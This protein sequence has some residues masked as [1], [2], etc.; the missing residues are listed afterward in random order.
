MSQE[1]SVGKARRLAAILHADVVGFSALMSADEA[2]T[3]SAVS[4]ALKLAR[5]TVSSHGGRLVGTAGDAFLA[6]F[7]SVLDAMTAAVEFQ[8]RPQTDDSAL[9]LKFRVGVN[10]GD[11]IVDGDDIYGD[12]I[13]VAARVEALAP[14]G[15]IAI[16]DA[17]FAQIGKRLDVAFADGGTHKVKNIAEPLHVYVASRPFAPSTAPSAPKWRPAAWLV[18]GVLSILALV[19]AIPVVVGWPWWD[20]PPVEDADKDSRPVI[21]VLP[22]SEAGAEETW[23]AD[24]MTED[25]I[26]HLGRFPELL[27]LSWN[28]VAPFRDR[29]PTAG[30][31]RDKLGASYVLSGSIRRNDNVLR[32]SVEFSDASD[33]LLIWSKRFHSSLEDVFDVQDQITGEVAGSL[34]IGVREIAQR[35]T[36][37]APTESLD[38]YELVLRGNTIYRTVERDDNLTARALFQRAIEQDPG[39]ADAYA[40]L[41]YSHIADVWWGW[42]ERPYES[43]EAA[44]AATDRAIEQ[45]P[46]NLRALTVRSEALFLNRQNDAAR[47]ACD[48][49]LDINPNDPAALSMC[50]SI[51]IFTGTPATAVPLLEL[52]LRIDQDLTSW[53]LS[54]L[55]VGHYLL[56]NYE[57]GAEVLGKGAR[58]FDEDPAPHAVLAALNVRLGR[59]DAAQ[60]EVDR[61]LRLY[62][63]FDVEIF[64]NNMGSAAQ[65]SNLL[66][67]LR[68][69]GF[70]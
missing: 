39:Y 56:G 12:G 14:P 63:F 55:A 57:R 58:G 44:L 23:F 9:Q 70:T 13:N 1:A 54:N 11:V 5:E 49:A 67:D 22:F 25:V 45:D 66:S 40:G 42:S 60:R 28:A 6:E 19:I 26:S 43:V 50:G 48:N 3:Q 30:E 35:R 38:A 15:G 69:A 68:A 65:E 20:A 29:A 32:L 59:S 21:A 36:L 34:A 64:V 33:G 62:P 7:P 46:N 53:A 8:N 27:V 31:L 47:A 16:T 37:E 51:R 10:L 41:A 24:G 2:A 4:S 61:A 52:A 17:V 18:T